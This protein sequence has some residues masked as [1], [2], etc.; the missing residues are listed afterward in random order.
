MGKGRTAIV[1]QRTKERIGVDL[2]ARAIQKTIAVI[3][4]NI[5][6]Q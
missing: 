6:P 5:I 1:L 2:V 4:A 3:A